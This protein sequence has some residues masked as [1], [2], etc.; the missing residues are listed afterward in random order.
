MSL[1]T[2]GEVGYMHAD[3]RYTLPTG[4][5]SLRLSRANLA[6]SLFL[7]FCGHRLLVFSHLKQHGSSHKQRYLETTIPKNDMDGRSRYHSVPLSLV[8]ARS[9]EA[10]KV[11][12]YEG[13]R[14][15]REVSL[16]H[17]L[18]L[19]GIYASATQERELVDS[20]REIAESHL[21]LSPPP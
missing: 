13:P 19:F 16:D 7:N 5:N 9:D 3:L 12:C 2:Q 17:H 15:K 18:A 4:S 1:Q 21:W 14:A 8:C 20:V 11:D 10:G 6:G